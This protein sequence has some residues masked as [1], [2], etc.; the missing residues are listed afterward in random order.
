LRSRLL[1]ASDRAGWVIDSV[2]D[3]VAERAYPDWR[4]QV[5]G[6]HWR[7]G[8][9][10]L[11]HLMSRSWLSLSSSRLR[12]AAERNALVA[13]WWHG[14]ASSPEPALRQGLEFLGDHQD[15]FARVHVPCISSANAVRAVGVED[16]RIVVLPEGVDTTR[17]SPT[18]ADRRAQIREELGVPR[19]CFA[20]GSFQKDGVGWEE[21]NDP[22]PVKAPGVLAHALAMLSR[23]FPICVV[24]PGSSR[25][26]LK[27]MLRDAGVRYIAPGFVPLERLPDYHRALDLYVSPSLEEGGPVGVLEAL[28][29]GTPVVATRTG[30][31]P[32]IMKDDREG[33]LVDVGDPVS[34]CEAMTRMLTDPKLRSTCAQSA[35]ETA[36]SLDWAALV[37]EYFRQLY[38]PCVR[39]AV[40]A[41]RLKQTWLDRCRG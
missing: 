33:R 29:T 24:I 10:C 14:S 11:V 31:A 27:R 20:I 30:M 39:D 37:P 32:D 15:L 6:D 7:F 1:I 40:L 9:D 26:Y 4:P 35:R 34:L 17:F 21:G 19:D 3:A 25:G 22:K 2:S 36:M 28:A 16:E 38:I 41:S 23:D 5:T 18:T 8:Q 12:G 13:L